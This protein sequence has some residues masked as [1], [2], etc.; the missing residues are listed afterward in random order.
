MSL[1]WFQDR[2]PLYL[3]PMAGVTD[4]VFRQLCKEYGADVMVTEFVSAEGIFRRNERTLEYLEFVEA[5]RPLGVQL[6]GGDPAHLGEA[7][8]MVLDWKQ[9]DFIDLNFGCP[10]NKV[11][12]KH[13]GSSLLRD[14]PLLEKV[15]R[16][17]VQAVAPHPVTAKM[18]IGWCDATINATTAARLLEDCGVQAIAVHGRTKEQGYSGEANWD[19]IAQ[20]AAT[21]RVPVIGNG[22]IGSAHGAARRMKT[23]VR[24][25]M[26]GRAAMSAPWV[27]RE[28][29]HFLATG[30]SLD[31]PA[32]AEQ[33][34]HIIRHCRWTVEREGS[35]PHA[36]AAMRSR[37]MAYS[38]GMPEAKRLRER[39]ARVASLAEL[40]DIAE[41]NIQH[42]AAHIPHPIG[43]V[44]ARSLVPL[45]VGC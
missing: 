16:A 1:P 7:A 13:G 41:E 43:A 37:L 3:A 15:A 31:P 33:W 11:V 38:R 36:M 21:V 20:V 14:C 19:V 2:F 25:L 9:P 22:D 12:A 40:E 32:L 23:G 6:F 17:V 30:E 28:I 4:T 26:L 35:E 8:R 34:A 24:G 42:S 18:R 29:K 44:D 10:V 39:F 45:D 27:F 5:E